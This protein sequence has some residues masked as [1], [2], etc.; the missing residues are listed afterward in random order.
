[1]TDDRLELRG[2]GDLPPQTET[3]RQAAA[4]QTGEEE[5]EAQVNRMRHV[6]RKRITAGDEFA[7]LG[8]ARHVY[9]FCSLKPR[10]RFDSSRGFYAAALLFFM[11]LGMPVYTDRAAKASTLYSDEECH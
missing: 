3:P 11:P 8:C 10:L 5:R 1:M 9:V 4:E 6:G 7:I 2:L